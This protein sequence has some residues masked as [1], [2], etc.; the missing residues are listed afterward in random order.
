MYRS[1]PTA[2]ANLINGTWDSLLFGLPVLQDRIMRSYE[3]AIRGASDRAQN[4]VSKM[5]G[6]IRSV[7]VNF[8]VLSGRITKDAVRVISQALE[9]KNDTVGRMEKLIALANPERAL[10]LGYSLTTD[11]VGVVV[12][13]ITKIKIGT[14][15][16]TLLANGLVESTVDKIN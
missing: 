13:D 5:V 9:K 15:L 7:F 12:R 14:R 2:V 4:F 16:K 11:A 10:R 8:E 3:N 6:Q 1:T